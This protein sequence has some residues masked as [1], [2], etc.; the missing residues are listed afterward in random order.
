VQ[1]EGSVVRFHPVSVIGE[2]PHGE[3]FVGVDEVLRRRVV[4]K[5]VVARSMSR[6]SRARLITEAQALCRLN[7]PNILQIYKYAEEDGHDV[8]T[9]EFAAGKK[10]PEVLARKVEL[11]EKVRIAIA[12]A[13]ALVVAHRNGITHGALSPSSV[14]IAENGEVKLTD[15]PS[16]ST[17]FEP[18][19]ESSAEVHAYAEDL[20]SHTA[21]MQAFGRLLREMFG[22][23][24]RDI[25]A[26]TAS[27]LHDAPSERPTAAEALTTLERI[28]ARR[29]RRI[30]AA[31]IAVVIA[32]FVIGAMKY[33]IDLRR[34]RSEAIAA[35]AE[36]EARRDRANELVAYM[37]K[38]I[39]AKLG[40]AGRLDIMDATSD[41]V[42][43]HFQS[44]QP[45]RTSATEASM[46]VQ[47]LVQ[48]GG[49][50][51][52]RGRLAAARVLL[53]QA[54]TLGE[55]TL[56]RFPNDAELRFNTAT[57]HA[58][59]STALD[60]SGDLD[61]AIQHARVFAGMVN[62]VA[63]RRPDN[64]DY[65]RNLAS[66]HSNL[67]T[68]YDRR[69]EIE[70][71]LREVELAVAVKRRALLLEDNAENRYDLAV[72]IHKMGVALLKMGRLDEA[73]RT[74]E[75]EQ[76]NLN[77]L[78]ARNSTQWRLRELV[79][80][81]D[82]D[83][84]MVTVSAGD[85][86]A[87]EKHAASYLATAKQLT[88]FDSENVD[89]K[90]AL[91]EAQRSAGTVARMRG[92]AAAAVE[93]NAASV[94][95]ISGLFARG[96][97]TT[98]LERDLIISRIELARSLLAAGRT[99]AALTQANVAVEAARP[100]QATRIGQRMLGVAL[101]VQ[102]E[103][104]DARGDRAGATES[105]EKALGVLGPL[106]EISPDPRIADSHA[107]VLLHLGR[108]DAAQPLIEQ[109]LAVGY[110]NREFEALYQSK[111]TFVGS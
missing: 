9:F 54:L 69:E 102:G 25:R 13:G 72:P 53:Q 105:W 38:D 27:L 43:S 2:G 62:E 14:L 59:M 104:R 89:W 8:F 76:A 5:K 47:A 63:R 37:I 57:A 77:A 79:T 84:L 106:D 29:G 88:S 58:V 31:A 46:N 95:V 107:R 49:A 35:R 41:K 93:H 110:R 32:L 73:R 78:L 33:T 34:E 90:R 82:H 20:T 80:V 30:R 91:A 68:L 83:L 99:N 111:G 45:E 26:L 19:R 81:F 96:R 11:A 55:A 52:A 22:D 65:V 3:V 50:Q 39:R 4:V 109:L 87:A 66:A 36:A 75:L 100:A 85:L 12:V 51:I 61:G 48:I 97:K 108:T 40:Y 24:D 103:I 42:L 94:D 16:M 10:L 74:L 21:D 23:K 98:L 64:P 86:D 28:A 70:A 101:L 56:A 67:G 1:R 18:L 7:H 15:F 6:D 71:S 44:M 60:R 92:D 17:T